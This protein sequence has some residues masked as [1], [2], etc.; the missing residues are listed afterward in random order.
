M[1]AV[2]ALRRIV[3][4]GAFSFAKG[5]YRA[6]LTRRS[7]V[8]DAKRL[9][10]KRADLTD[11][12]R[13][14][15]SSVSPVIHAAD[16]M[17]LGDAE[18]YLSVGLSAMRSAKAVLERRP[19]PIPVRHALDLPSG[20]GRELRFLVEA[21]PL[22]RFTACDI[23]EQAVDFCAS[24]FECDAVYAPARIPDLKL[25]QTFQM[26]WCGSLIT[27]LS[28]ANIRSL[29]TVFH[30]CLDPGGVMILTTAGDFSFERIGR[31][32]H[33]YGIDADAA[34]RIRMS[35]QA[36]GFGF[37]PYPDD[38][39]EPTESKLMEHDYGVTLTS[40]GWLRKCVADAGRFEEIYYQHRGWDEYLDV[41]GF[42]KLG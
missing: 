41:F 20:H 31:E 5:V 6:W 27:H 14:M 1:P 21:F 26:I 9:L 39:A 17:F 12:E 11:E 34:G 18:H 32:P 16:G 8:H 10:S 24:E 33:W 36:G 15:A 2:H 35:Y 7:R 37:A 4:K 13:T 29:L 25:S 22:A 38:Y 42:V 40:P 30:D 28:E 3:P 19:Y 23:I